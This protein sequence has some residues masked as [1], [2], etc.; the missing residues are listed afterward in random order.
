[1]TDIKRV[2][3]T[4]IH[5]VEGNIAGSRAARLTKQRDKQKEEYEAVKS[6]I[7]AENSAA[8]GR[9]DDKFNAATETAEDEFRRRTVGLVTAEDFRKAR[10]VASVGTTESEKRQ[11]ELELQAEEKKKK[12]KD[13]K[14]KKMASALSF[15]MDD[16]DEDGNGEGAEE[17]EITLKRPLKKLS[18][19]PN[20]ETSFLPDRERDLQHEK[21]RQRLQE[22][23]MKEQEI[24]KNEVSADN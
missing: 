15:A 10:E 5:T 4:G 7:K 20:V 12:A 16:G 11:Q 18:K 2:G 17:E 21:D 24:I 22:E 6:K 13:Q 3:D 9:I 23:W 1:M 8:V 14:R 19:D